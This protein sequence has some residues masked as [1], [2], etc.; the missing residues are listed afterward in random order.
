MKQSMLYPR[1]SAARR[2]TDLGGMWKFCL[3][4][5]GKGDQ[6][7]WKDGIPGTEKIPVPASFN[8]FYTDKDIRE[9][10]GDFW[11]ETE[12]FV[13]GEWRKMHVDLRFAALTHRG[14]VY[15]NGQE[16]ISH[17]GG[18]LP[19]SARIDDVVRWNEKNLV[20]VKGNNE[21]SFTSL[22]AGFT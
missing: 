3:D 22:P 4:W 5:D 20:V 16:V 7:G 15:V 18:F 13:P 8:D 1:A 9:F 14:T 2:V 21:L 11:Y 19:F 6:E 10:A 12:V 17:E